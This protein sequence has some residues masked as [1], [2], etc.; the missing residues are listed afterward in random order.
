MNKERRS[1]TVISIARVVSA[2]FL[3]MVIVGPAPYGYLMWVSTIHS[4]LGSLLL[5][6]VYGLLSALV[7][8]ILAV[9]LLVYLIAALLKPEDF[10]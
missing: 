5:I 7:A 9:L 2:A 10:L 1:G 8:G 6:V 4:L 3:A